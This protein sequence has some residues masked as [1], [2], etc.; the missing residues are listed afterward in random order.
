MTGPLILVGAVLVVIAPTLWIIF[1]RRRDPRSRGRAVTWVAFAILSSFCLLA[2]LFVAGEALEDPGGAAGL[3]LLV[4]WLVPALV[5]I[6][7]AA[8]DP[9]WASWVFAVLTAAVVASA[10]VWSAVGDARL[11]EDRIGPV[12]AVVVIA[13]A[14]A[15]GP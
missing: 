14:A 8:W 2:G 5:L 15:L 9:R 10:M 6:A 1:R 11:V 3:L 13:L 12:R 7:V 4:S